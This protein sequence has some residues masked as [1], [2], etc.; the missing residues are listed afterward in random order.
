MATGR[1]LALRP[2]SRGRARRALSPELSLGTQGADAHTVAGYHPLDTDRT[3]HHT[4]DHA[5]HGRPVVVHHH[6][7]APSVTGARARAAGE[8]ERDLV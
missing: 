5:G 8:G 6:H 7:S 1:L 3:E 4:D 2:E